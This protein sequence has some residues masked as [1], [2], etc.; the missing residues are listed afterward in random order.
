MAGHQETWDDLESVLS[1]AYTSRAH[2][3]TGGVPL[4]VLV[5]E[6]DKTLSQESLPKT[7]YPWTK[8]MSPRDIREDYR[9]RL[10]SLVQ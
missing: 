1:L 6:R 2:A 3:S 10:R 5:P 8:D 9:V 4:V 7:A